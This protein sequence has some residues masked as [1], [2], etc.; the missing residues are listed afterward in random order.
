MLLAIL[1]NTMASKHAEDKIVDLWLCFCSFRYYSCYI[2]EYFLDFFFR[3][4]FI[5]QEFLVIGSDPIFIQIFLH[6]FKIIMTS[7]EITIIRVEILTNTIL[8]VDFSLVFCLSI[9]RFNS[10]FVEFIFSEQHGDQSIR[11]KNIL[12]NLL[13]N[14]IGF[15]HL[16]QFKIIAQNLKAVTLNCPGNSA[17]KISFIYQY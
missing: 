5:Q 13:L 9:P 2:H 3:W 14:A 16:E 8:L 15:R 11:P 10:D 12:G 1:E 6:R 17:N 7:Q 4:M